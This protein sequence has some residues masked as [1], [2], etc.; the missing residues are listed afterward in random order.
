MSGVWSKHYLVIY[1]EEEVT[2]EQHR[3]EIDESV[4][5]FFIFYTI[6]FF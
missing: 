2:G 5:F 6:L 4:E 3:I 1:N